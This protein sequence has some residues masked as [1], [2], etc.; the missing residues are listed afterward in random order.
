MLFLLTYDIWGN[1]EWYCWWFRNPASQLRLV[2]YPIIYKV[3]KT[4]Q[5]VVGDFF[6]QPYQPLFLAKHQKT[7]T[8]HQLSKI[9]GKHIDGSRWI[10][11]Y[12][13]IYIFPVIFLSS[14]STSGCLGGSYCCHATPWPGH[15]GLGHGTYGDLVEESKFF[16]SVLGRFGTH[17]KRGWKHNN[18]EV[19]LR[20]YV[21][22]CIHTWNLWL[23]VLDFGGFS[24]S[25][26]RSKLHS[27]QGSSKGSSIRQPSCLETGQRLHH[28]NERN[29]W[30]CIYIYICMH[31]WMFLWCVKCVPKFTRKIYTKGRTFLHIWKIQVYIL[32]L[33]CF[34]LCPFLVFFGCLSLWI[35]YSMYGLFT[36]GEAIA[37]WT[38]GN[39]LVYIP[40][41]WLLQVSG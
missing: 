9:S 21:C 2:V 31:T 7:L 15:R 18:L 28:W 10:Y 29:V 27:K 5:V 20:V 25:K 3:S 14:S 16:V 19:F 23:F 6:H 1:K 33:V 32:E 34:V 36:L 24:P 22:V 11:I 26:A 38:R 41:P 37:T 8:F 13:Y 12:I 30:V 17:E 40:V 4:S 39:G 35:R